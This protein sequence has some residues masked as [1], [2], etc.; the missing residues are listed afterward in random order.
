[1]RT[2]LF[3]EESRTQPSSVFPSTSRIH[4]RHGNRNYELATPLANKGILLHD[5][6]FEIPGE[7]QQVIW[8]GFPDAIRGVDRDVR[9][10]QEFPLLVR[11]AVDRIVEK[12]G[13]NPAIIQQRI[14]FARSAVARDLFP[15]TL[16]LDQEFKEFAFGF[17]H[18]LGE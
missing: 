18:L 3:R 11:A 8:P 14:P 4:F 15:R 6:I 1:M 13:S 12:I 7:N 9:P 17:S 10:W 16:G 2:A 5:F